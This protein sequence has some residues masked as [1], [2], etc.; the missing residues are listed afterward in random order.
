VTWWA[1]PLNAQVA[2]LPDRELRTLLKTVGI[3]LAEARIGTAQK[4]SA[5]Q[6]LVPGDEMSTGSQGIDD[7]PASF[8]SCIQPV[9]GT[10]L[11]SAEAYH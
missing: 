2:A 7:Y 6:G 1:W 9:R 8:A 5:G 3:Q 4:Q 11:K 10:L